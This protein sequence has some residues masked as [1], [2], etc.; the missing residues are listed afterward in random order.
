MTKARTAHLAGTQRNDFGTL[1]DLVVDGQRLR[2]HD[3]TG[4]AAST[5][6]VSLRI[7]LENALRFHDGTSR[8]AD[9]IRAI[10]DGPGAP[11]D[12]HASRVFLH[13]TNGVPTLVDLAA[14]RDGMAALGSDPA[15]VNPIIASELV[16]DHSVIADVY[17]TPDALVRNAELEYTRNGERYRFLRWGQRAE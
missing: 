12:L 15:R 4:I 17:G 2:Y 13:D 8:G 5:L 6:P 14:I 7:V 9:Q 11:V 1:R 3:T 16:V 10:I